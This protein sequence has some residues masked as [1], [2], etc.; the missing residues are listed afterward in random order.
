[1]N[2]HALLCGAASLVKLVASKN[3]HAAFILFC[4][5]LR[6]FIEV[7]LSFPI[8]KR[9]DTIKKSEILLSAYLLLARAKIIVFLAKT[10]ISKNHSSRKPNL[11]CCAACLGLQIR[12]HPNI[13]ISSIL[14][15]F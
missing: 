12:M 11:L 7:F 8:P 14:F 10:K 5:L 6:E 4:L 15:V 3:E 2:E 1:M 13:Q 9:H